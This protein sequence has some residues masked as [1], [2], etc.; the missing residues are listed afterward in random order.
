MV[1]TRYKGIPA[2]IFDSCSLLTGNYVAYNYIFFIVVNKNKIASGKASEL[3][4]FLEH[5][6]THSMQ[7]KRDGFF[8]H[9]WNYYFNEDYRIFCEI[10]AYK[11]QREIFP[12]TDEDI[13][14][15]LQIYSATYNSEQLMEKLT[16]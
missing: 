8:F 9:T 10:E 11:R 13:V 6:Y 16:K 2:F 12:M 4:S 5:E 1:Y 7:A 15:R 3:S 14:G